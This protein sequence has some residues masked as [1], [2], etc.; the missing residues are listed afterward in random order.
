[1]ATIDR[2]VSARVMLSKA[3][4][5]VGYGRG[6]PAARLCARR[7][8]LERGKTARGALVALPAGER[9]R[10]TS[11][12]FLRQASLFCCLEAAAPNGRDARDS[13]RSRIGPKRQTMHF[14]CDSPQKIS[15]RGRPWEVQMV[16]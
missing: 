8:E 12:G 3:I 1:M 9:R 2:D 7:G 10:S 13:I 11:C 5:S 4:A 14:L 15:A 16:S 6:P